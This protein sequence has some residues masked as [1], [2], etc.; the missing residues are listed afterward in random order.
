M[1]HLTGTENIGQAVGRGQSGL[2]R[3]LDSRQSR[4]V[5]QWNSR[6][7][8]SKSKKQWDS[9]QGQ[10]QIGQT[11][12][13]QPEPIGQTLGQQEGAEKQIDQTVGQWSETVWIGQAVDSK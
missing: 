5:R 8:Q 9:K 2:D 10:K 13:Q 6:K 12:G 4:S 11:V 7:G 3:L 1:G